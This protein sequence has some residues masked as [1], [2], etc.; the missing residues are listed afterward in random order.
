MTNKMTNRKALSIAIAVLND[1]GTE[2]DLNTIIIDG[3]GYEAADVVAKL[4]S[5]AAALDNKAANTKKKPTKT[6]LENVGLRAAI[7]SF[8]QENPNLIVTCTDL[9]KK[10]PELDDM[11]NQKISALVRGL[12]DGGEVTKITEKG[13][14]FFK[15][16]QP[17]EGS[18]SGE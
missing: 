12:V 1:R 11:N 9:G 5:M 16:A 4:E 7:M 6:Q 17:T 13:K 8:L 10:V 3:V 2:P 14:S 15:L 18:E